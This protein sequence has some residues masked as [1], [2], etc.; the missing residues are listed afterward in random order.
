MI[1]VTFAGSHLTNT[2]N[3]YLTGFKRWLSVIMKYQKVY[4][5]GM[6]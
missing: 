3:D 1:F 2:E 4:A 5:G 6:T